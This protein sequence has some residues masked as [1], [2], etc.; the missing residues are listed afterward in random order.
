MNKTLKEL[1]D[2]FKYILEETY[3]G[4]NPLFPNNT[5]DTYQEALRH[6]LMQLYHELFVSSEFTLQRYFKDIKGNKIPLKNKSERHDLSI[7]QLNFLMELKNAD[8]IDESHKYQLLSYMD[9]SDFKYGAIINFRKF[10]PS[11]KL[12]AE[13]IIYEK[14]SEKGEVN[15]KG[16]KNLCSKFKEIGKVET[17]DFNELSGGY[18]NKEIMID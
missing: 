11:K 4:C 1:L 9:D 15:E 2:N 12:V 6:N 5:E 13:A 17:E 18:F 10:K 8:K 16:E 3:F 7:T 14:I